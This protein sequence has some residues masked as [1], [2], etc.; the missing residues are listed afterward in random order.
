MFGVQEASDT[1]MNYFKNG[2]PG[3]SGISDMY[4]FV[5]FGRDANKKGEY[6]AV[7]YNT[8][9]Y[10]VVAIVLSFLAKN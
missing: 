6:S 9:K 4:N 7:F 1:W 3:V 10:E 5:G 8:S 2:V